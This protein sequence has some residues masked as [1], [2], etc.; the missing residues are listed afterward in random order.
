MHAGIDLREQEL[1][2]IEPRQTGGVFQK[3]AR[4][5]PEYRDY[6]SGPVG[7]SSWIAWIKDRIGDLRAIRREC[8]I[9]F[10]PV[11]ICKALSFSTW[12]YLHVNL[13][14]SQEIALSA[15]ES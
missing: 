4:I 3:E 15:N 12:Q 9:V 13:V 14:G 6:I 8:Q 11:V 1:M 10:R 2:L 7:G 5:A